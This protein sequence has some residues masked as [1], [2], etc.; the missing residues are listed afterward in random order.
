MA[1]WETRADLG[2]TVYVRKGQQRGGRWR[3]K[4]EPVR[5]RFNHWSFRVE[6]WA[7]DE[8]TRLGT[9]DAYIGAYVR[10]G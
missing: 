10:D 6:L 5:V 4:L 1:D 2:K 3:P 7:K 8:S 9:F